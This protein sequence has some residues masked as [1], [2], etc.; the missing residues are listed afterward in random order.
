MLVIIGLLLCLYLAV[1]GLEFQHRQ[2]V[3][4]QADGRG[5]VLAAFST[6]V[7]LLGAVAFALLVIMQGATSAY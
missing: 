3:S 7:C 4:A 1:K 2:R 6:V 5:S